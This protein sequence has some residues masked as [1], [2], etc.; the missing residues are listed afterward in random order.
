MPLNKQ[1]IEFENL[2]IYTVTV[3][4]LGIRFYKENKIRKKI[5]NEIQEKLF[6]YPNIIRDI[7]K[8]YIEIDQVIY[9]C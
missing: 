2:C 5:I 9:D 6:L 1:L 8:G 7:M 4:D 3:F